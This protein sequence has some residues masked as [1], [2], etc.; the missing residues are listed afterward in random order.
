MAGQEK[1]ER[2]SLQLAYLEN[3]RSNHVMILC[4]K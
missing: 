1:H 4:L 3:H 2:D